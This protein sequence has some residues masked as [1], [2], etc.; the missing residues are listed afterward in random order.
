MLEF[1]KVL[2]RLARFAVSEAGQRACL[3]LFPK[4]VP[5]EIERDARLFEQAA[6]FYARAGF[7]LTAFP[8]LEGVFRYLKSRP[9]DLDADALWAVRQVLGLAKEARKAVAANIQSGVAALSW[10]LLEELAL[11]CPAAANA[12]AALFRCLSDDGLIRDESSPD[13]LLIRQ[14][15]RGLHQQCLRKAKDFAQRY[16]IAQYL[17]DEFMTL[18]AD[19]YVLPLKANFKGRLQGII[20]DYSQTGETCYFEPMFLVE[21]NNTLQELKRRERDEE[22]RVVHYLTG[23]VRQ[24][25]AAIEGAYLFLAELDVLAAKCALARLYDGRVPRF[26][27]DAPVHLK[28]A[29]HPLLALGDAAQNASGAPSGAAYGDAGGTGGTDRLSGKRGRAGKTVPVDIMIREN[30]YGLI[31]S[32]GNAGGKTVTLKTLGLIALLGMSGIPA[33]VEAGSRLPLWDNIFAFIGDEQSIEDHVSTFTAQIEHL[34]RIWPELGPNCLVILDEFGAGT[35][36]AQGAALAQAVMDEILE[37]KAYVVAATHFPALKTYALSHAGV[38]AASV[39]FDPSSKRPLYRLAYDQVGASRALDVARDHGL[40]EAVIRRAEQYLLLDGGDVTALVERLNALAVEREKEA[41]RLRA[42]EQR[43]AEKRKRLEERFEAE[44]AAL[45]AEVR[46]IGQDVLQRYREGR[47]SHKSALKELAKARELLQAKAAVSGENGGG[48]AGPAFDDLEKG[49]TVRY[50][51]WDRKAYIE[52]LDA[53]KQR[54]KINLSGVSMWVSITELSVCGKPVQAAAP[55]SGKPA[56]APQSGAGG[57][58]GMRPARNAEQPSSRTGEE[59]VAALRVDVRGQRADE[60]VA[61]LAAFLDRAV[62]QGFHAVEVIHGR[63]TGALRK[64]IHA[65][66]RQFPAVA[67]YKL[68]TEEFGGDGVTVVSLK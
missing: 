43:L 24:E 21:L 45:A 42:E 40:D 28:N 25:Q 61:S 23:L 36:P 8:S 57:V 6:I 41:A 67:S 37:K 38:R 60:A 26:E 31:I 59:E 52:D 58:K 63:G 1:E 5:E 46:R 47:A 53:R 10:P 7:A 30:E 19:R 29:R 62:L 65:F 32:G 50:A 14:E 9:D 3:S 39:L 4:N 54:A 44:R 51:P 66:L 11:S 22:R 48:R 68:A 56:Q 15:I 35:D 64:E 20:H 27:K 17:Q 2:R 12:T 13:L 16:N 34:S 33:P 18:S 49:M 55:D